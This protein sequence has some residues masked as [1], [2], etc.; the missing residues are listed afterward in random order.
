MTSERLFNGL[1]FT[2]GTLGVLFLLIRRTTLAVTILGL[3][4]G[5]ADPAC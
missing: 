2:G 3:R 1:L 5:I 4:P